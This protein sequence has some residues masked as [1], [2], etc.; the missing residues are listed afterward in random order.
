MNI[1]TILYIIIVPFSIWI[2]TSMRL[3][4]LFKKGRI[5]QIVLFNVFVSL[6]IAYLVVNFLYDFYEV[7]RII[8]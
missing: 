6:G 2:V 4:Q 3:E 1:K 7:S 8:S 5:S